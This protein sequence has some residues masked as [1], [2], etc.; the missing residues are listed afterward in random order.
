[1]EVIFDLDET[2]YCEKQFIRHGFKMVSM[3]LKTRGIDISIRELFNYQEKFGRENVIDHVLRERGISDRNILLN[4]IYAYR[5]NNG[6]LTP[7]DGFMEVLDFLPTK[8]SLVTDGMGFVQRKKLQNIGLEGRFDRIYFTDEWGA[9]AAKP[10]L[11]C[12]LDILRQ[13]SLSPNEMVYIGDD[14]S[15]DFVNLNLIGVK[16]IRI[17]QG[18]FRDK[19][20]EPDYDAVISIHN[21]GELREVLKNENW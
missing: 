19:I 1:M 9:A 15:K 6:V 12:F 14:P 7:R 8:P 18:R 17:L 11:V 2:I 10:S 13:K 3:Y 5:N 20:A 21:F 4:S 16:T